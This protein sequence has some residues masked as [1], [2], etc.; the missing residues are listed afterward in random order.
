MKITKEF[1]EKWA[2][3]YADKESGDFSANVQ[4]TIEQHIILKEKLQHA[5]MFGMELVEKTRLE[6]FDTT[7]A[8]DLK[9]ALRKAADSIKTTTLKP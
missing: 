6:G 5:A 7:E 4:L 9:S 8:K 1:F 3:N 2:S